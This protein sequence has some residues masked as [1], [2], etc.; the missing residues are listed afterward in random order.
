M[1]LFYLLALCWFSFYYSLFILN[2]YVLCFHLCEWEFL[3]SVPNHRAELPK[4]RET[5]IPKFSQLQ[6]HLKNV[7]LKMPN[8]L[9]QQWKCDSTTVQCFPKNSEIRRDLASTIECNML[10]SL[11][12]CCWWTMITCL[13][14]LS[15]VSLTITGNTAL[16]SEPSDLSISRCI[17]SV[18]ELINFTPAEIT[19]TEPCNVYDYTVSCFCLFVFVSIC[20]WSNVYLHVCL[21]VCFSVCLSACLSLTSISSVHNVFCVFVNFVFVNFPRQHFGHQLIDERV[22]FSDSPS[23]YFVAMIT[24]FYFFFNWFST[25]S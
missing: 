4:T 21:S 23:T 15:D 17:R 1:Y 7:N 10:A 19:F 2:V 22:G 13:S 5:V 25:V 12:Y 6:L 18:I 16:Y 24:L 9:I 8:R 14:D 20:P 3:R 11:G